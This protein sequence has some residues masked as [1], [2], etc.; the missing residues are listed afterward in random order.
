MELQ[1]Y[2]WIVLRIVYAWMFL[3]AP[4]NLVKDWDNTVT[5]TALLFKLQ[6]KLFAIGSIIGMIISALFI[7][8]GIYARIGGIFL[9]FFNL[10]AAYIH[11]QLAKQAE[12]FKTE[13]NQ[14]LIALAVLGNVTSAQKNFVLAA[15]AFFFALQGSG[16]WS[17][18]TL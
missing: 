9:F 4:L 13:G 10:G 6:P 2:A 5:T 18:I 16:P 8:F 11:F 12:T 3:Y 1:P 15:I 17:I 14:P 7:L